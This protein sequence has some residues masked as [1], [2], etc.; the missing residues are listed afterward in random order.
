MKL[1]QLMLCGAVAAMVSP[2]IAQVNTAT[3]TNENSSLAFTRGESSASFPF[4]LPQRLEWVVDGRRILVYPSNPSVF[5]NVNNHLHGSGHVE[6][7]QLHAQGNVLGYEASSNPKDVSGRVTGAIVY[8]VN[9]G[10]AGSGISRISEKVDIFNRSGEAIP[11]TLGGL[12]WKPTGTGAHDRNLEIPD[13]SGLDVTGTT[14]AFVQ[15]NGYRDPQ[16]AA[17]SGS[18]VDRPEANANYRNIA[19]NTNPTF[20]SVTVY[21][22]LSFSGFNTFSRNITLP[23][24][25]TLSM[26]TEIN[27]K[28]STINGPIYEG[29]SFSTSQGVVVEGSHLASLDNGDWAGYTQ[30][31]FGTGATVFEALVAVDPQFAN[32][33][34]EIKL[35]SPT[36]TKI[37]EMI[38]QSTGS[39]ANF[40][41]QSTNLNQ[42]VSGM[43]DVYFLAVGSF[44]VGNVDKFRFTAR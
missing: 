44:G 23:A 29:E 27:V 40:Q 37:G 33:K 9:G 7:Y 16:G 26:I 43:Q 39:F 31:N 22:A 17:H 13:I 42:V 3:V 25:A 1:S 2:C 8:T 11:L 18:I 20:A 14:V 5:I 41:W 24:G 36:G 35:G 19:D 28:K 21:P 32:Q 30:L 15:G 34:L 12:G 38:M 6:P 4:S 10:A